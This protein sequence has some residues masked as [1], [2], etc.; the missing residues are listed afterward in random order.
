LDQK[1]NEDHGE[2]R[3]DGPRNLLELQA[4][5][6]AQPSA[7]VL[8]CSYYTLTLLHTGRSLHHRNPTGAQRAASAR[9]GFLIVCCSDC[10]PASFPYESASFTHSHTLSLDSC[11]RPTTGKSSS[12]AGL[13]TL[14]YAYVVDCAPASPYAYSLSTHRFPD[15][16]APIEATPLS[17]TSAELCLGL[18]LGLGWLSGLGLN[19]LLLAS[20]FF[21]LSHTLSLDSCCRPTTGKSS[22]PVGLSSLVYAYVVDCAP[23]SPYAYSTHRF[24]DERTP[25]EATPLSAT[26]AELGLGLRLGLG[27]DSLARFSSHALPFF[28]PPSFHMRGPCL[29][30]ITGVPNTKLCAWGEEDSGGHVLRET[31][32]RGLCGLV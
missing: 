1:S 7:L 12:P 18:G 29:L 15:E 31:T 13:S 20:A 28:S 11:C 21:T 5:H 26:S 23:A 22:S 2:E 6:P 24:P 32:S 17:A 16:R 19:F 14:V 30:F 9:S 8:Y 3:S 27:L 4:L 10:T 25:I